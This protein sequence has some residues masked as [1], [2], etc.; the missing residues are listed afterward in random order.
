MILFVFVFAVRN[1]L[2]RKNSIQDSVRNPFT[3]DHWSSCIHYL[4]LLPGFHTWRTIMTLWSIY[5]YSL[6][7]TLPSFW[8]EMQEIWRI[9][10]APFQS[11]WFLSQLNKL[12]PED[13]ERWRCGSSVLQ[14]RQETEMLKILLFLWDWTWPAFWSHLLDP[15]FEKELLGQE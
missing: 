3:S 8:K 7:H 13:A 14:S 15:T 4:W 9:L 1:V 6:M 10:V 12:H 2:N 5:L 11:P